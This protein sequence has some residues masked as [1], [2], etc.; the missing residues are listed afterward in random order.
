MPGPDGRLKDFDFK[1]MSIEGYDNVKK[2]FVATSS[3]S[4]STGI[5]LSEGTYNPATKTFTYTGEYEMVPGMKSKV[6]ELI[7]IV[8][9]DH[10]VFEW[11]EDE[12]GQESEDDGDNLHA[13][14]VADSSRIVLAC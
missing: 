9:S 12:G 4:M 6:R 5:F 3:D 14:E 8:D 2:K 10:Y 1:G 11:Y 13:Q 7:K